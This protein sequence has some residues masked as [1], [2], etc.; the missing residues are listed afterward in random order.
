IRVSHLPYFCCAN[1]ADMPPV[2]PAESPRTVAKPLAT[3]Q[4]CGLRTPLPACPA[5]LKTLH[6]V[7]SGAPVLENSS[8]AT[9]AP[10]PLTV[11]ACVASGAATA[12]WAVAEPAAGA[13]DVDPFTD[14]AGATAA[15]AASTPEPAAVLPTGSVSAL[16]GA[17]ATPV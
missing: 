13:T 8:P 6:F 12:A 11:A 15:G 10:Q 1:L 2:V 4:A 7:A 14:A 17:A 16:T 3:D 9:T 5:P